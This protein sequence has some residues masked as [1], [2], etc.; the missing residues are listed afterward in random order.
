MDVKLINKKCTSCARFFANPTPPTMVTKRIGGGVFGELAKTPTVVVE[1]PPAPTVAKTP[2]RQRSQHHWWSRPRGHHLRRRTKTTQR[3]PLSAHRAPRS[4][5]RAAQC[6]IT[7][8]PSP[9]G[10]A[11]HRNHGRQPTLDFQCRYEVIDLQAT[12]SAYDHLH[13]VRG[14]RDDTKCVSGREQTTRITLGY[15]TTEPYSLVI[16]FE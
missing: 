15:S 14:R 9:R 2:D 11:R 6:S 13:D 7:L 10:A 3:P 8:G 5:T 16:R 1:L 4:L 12:A